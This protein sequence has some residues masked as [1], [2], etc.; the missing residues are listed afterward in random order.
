MFIEVNSD[1][2]LNDLVLPNEMI[3]RIKRI[4]K[5]FIQKDK[6][7]KYGLTSRRK[8]LFAGKRYR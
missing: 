1:Q 8:L 6:L 2:R 3:S 4:E 7:Q 5:E